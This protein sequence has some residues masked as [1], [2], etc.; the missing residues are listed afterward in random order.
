MHL[1]NLEFLSI[2]VTFILFV[3]TVPAVKLYSSDIHLLADGLSSEALVC[4]VL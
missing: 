4:G 1:N 3:N 2:F